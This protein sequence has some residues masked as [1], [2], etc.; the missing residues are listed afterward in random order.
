MK[1]LQLSNNLVSLSASLKGVKWFNNNLS[2]ED[3]E[4]EIK[5]D[6]ASYFS[7]IKKVNIS[8]ELEEYED[9]RSLSICTIFNLEMLLTFK[10]KV[11][12]DDV[13]IIENYLMKNFIKEF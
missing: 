5:A 7:F 12:F 3:I 13:V 6:I 1:V 8:I 11:D 9:V 2:S 4:E 10:D